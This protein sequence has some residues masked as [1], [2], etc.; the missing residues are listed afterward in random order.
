M[1]PELGYKN[2]TLYLEDTALGTLAQAFGTPCYAYSL[3]AL[4][5]TIQAWQT[6]LAPLPHHLCCYAVKANSTLGLLRLFAQRGLGFDI[7]SQG[8]LERV[9]KAGGDPKKI[10]FSG[11][12]KT[13]EAIARALAVGIQCF[14]VESWAECERI[15]Q[16]ATHLNLR[17]PVA[18]RLNPNVKAETHPHIQT[19]HEDHKFGIALQDI[20]PLLAR[21]GAHPHLKWIGVTAHIGSQICTLD[22]FQEAW[23]ILL[24]LADQLRAQGLPIEQINVGGGLGVPYREETPPS[25]AAFGQALSA[26]FQSTPYRL[27]VEPGR[28]LVA[29]AGLL[30][31]RCEYIKQTPHK[32][33]LILDTGMNDFI[34]PAL[35]DAWQTILP[36]QASSAPPEPYDVVGP[37]CESADVFGTQRNLPPLQAGDLLAILDAGAYGSSMS[38]H[39][40][41]RPRGA[42]LLVHQSQYTCIRLKETWDALWQGEI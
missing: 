1:I 8:E 16:I 14:Q 42:E 5:R 32:K 20:P 25:I 12:G 28:S 6:A 2:Q 24:R 27:L 3:S 34:R 31:A 37:I 7:V 30:L 22:P 4:L 18:I 35:Y 13:A 10:V 36:L 41:S 19:G 26:S 29:Q 11:V 15:A 17:A 33:L 21:Y 39:Y 40:N 9:L 38:S 23:S